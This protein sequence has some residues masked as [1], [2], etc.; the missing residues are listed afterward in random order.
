MSTCFSYTL[1]LCMI[2]CTKMKKPI[3]LLLYLPLHLIRATYCG[4][5]VYKVFSKLTRLECSKRNCYFMV[6]VERPSS[7]FSPI[8]L[9]SFITCSKYVFRCM[10]I[11]RT[12][13]KY[14]L[15]GQVPMF[16]GMPAALYQYCYRI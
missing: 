8:P 14:C 5:E 6:S 13:S 15:P 10:K 11:L 3:K 16:P 12:L 9:S 7:I 1:P 4:S 2:G